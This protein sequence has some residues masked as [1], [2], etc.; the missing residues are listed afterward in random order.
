VTEHQ[1][2]RLVGG[3]R[4]RVWIDAINRMLGAADARTP[5]RAAHLLAQVLHE[6]NG[7]R[8]T[9][10]NLAYSAARL[11]QVWPSRFTPALAE[12]MA[13]QPVA[14]ANHAYGGR[15][16]NT[17]PGDGWRFRGRGLIQLT[18]RANY[19][20]FEAAGGGPVTT[21]P[22]LLAGPPTAALA[23]SWYWAARAINRL[24]DADH[25]EGVTRAINGGTNGIADRARW[26]AAAKEVL[27]EAERPERLDGFEVFVVHGLTVKAVLAAMDALLDGDG[28]ANLGPVVASRTG[29]RKID[30][31]L[32]A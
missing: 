2:A 1:L 12:S 23:A 18:G 21:D 11:Q 10:E 17:Q 5:L 4:A 31:R 28:S 25:L 9:V 15:L 3:D 29:A 14:I 19:A 16:G 27:A 7:L 26:L 8:V 22:D 24:A 6:T 30:V 32:T 20:A 13:G